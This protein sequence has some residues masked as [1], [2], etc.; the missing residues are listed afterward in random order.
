MET[1]QPGYSLK[2]PH[3]TRVFLRAVVYLK[4]VCD[5][6]PSFDSIALC[7]H[8]IIITGLLLK[9]LCK[10]AQDLYAMVYAQHTAVSQTTLTSM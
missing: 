8:I 9:F 10:S 6:C 3:K 7:F 5:S 1:W 4:N 2:L